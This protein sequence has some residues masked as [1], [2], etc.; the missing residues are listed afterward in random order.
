MGRRQPGPGW[1]VV[2]A[3]NTRRQQYPELHLF[4]ALVSRNLQ[5]RPHPR[6]RGPGRQGT[7]LEHRRQLASQ[8]PRRRHPGT[9]G[10]APL[11]RRPVGAGRTTRARNRCGGRSDRTLALHGSGKLDALRQRRV[12]PVRRHDH[13]E[14]ATSVARRGRPPISPNPHPGLIGKDLPL[15]RKFG[16]Q[17]PPANSGATRHGF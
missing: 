9:S 17:I 12:V 3:G 15:I 11:H 4:P 7:G 14:S 10:S 6:G 13:R 16:N 1:R 8:Q 2:D 5:H